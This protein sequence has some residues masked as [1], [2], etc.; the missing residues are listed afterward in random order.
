M[1][2]VCLSSLEVYF[3]STVL[4]LHV[5]SKTLKHEQEIALFLFPELPLSLA[6]PTSSSQHII[7]RTLLTSK[8]GTNA[9]STC[10]SCQ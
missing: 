7:Q 8:M 3:L 4:D 2:G 5:V 9:I 1:T 6:L 10:A